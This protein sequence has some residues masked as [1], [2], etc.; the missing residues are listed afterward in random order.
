VAELELALDEGMPAL[1]A[2]FFRAGNDLL[3]LLDELAVKPVDWLLTDLRL[4]S[5]VAR[6]SAPPGAPDA[7]EYLFRA[8]AGLT[9][10]RDGLPLP[11][12]WDP[13]AVYAAR[14]LAAVD[15]SAGP[16]RLRLV[17]DDRAA[18]VIDLNPALAARLAELQPAERT[19]P[20]AVRGRVVGVKIARGNR[21]SLRTPGGLVVK[22]AFPNDLRPS[23]R[24]ALYDDVELVGDMRQDRAGRVFHIRADAV[25]RLTEPDVR[26]VD[27]FGI[28]P[29]IT[30]GLSV[31]D[32]LEAA[33][34]EA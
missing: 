7:A 34:G 16:A 29:D 20:G 28:D 32:Y 30:G 9:A 33:R 17:E 31:S 14:R 8:T 10:V 1:A 21:A 27:L 25:H 18:E 26:W 24:D 2:H 6:V 4:G 22:V 19:M 12:G 13:D 11:A 5:S 23:L 3:N 15:V